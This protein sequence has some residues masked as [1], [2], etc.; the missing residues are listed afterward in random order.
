M[1]PGSHYGKCTDKCFHAFVK[2]FIKRLDVQLSGSVK[3]SRFYEHE[4][5]VVRKLKGNEEI[6][7]GG[8]HG[9]T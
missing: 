8:K 4:G 7:K 6:L 1:V 2:I 9:R 3:M 5:R